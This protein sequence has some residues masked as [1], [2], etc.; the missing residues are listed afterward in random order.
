METR[1][2][3]II[4]GS[5]VLGLM[6]G[7]VFFLIWLSQP[8]RENRKSYDIQFRQSVGGLGKGAQVTYSG[9][10]V[11][12]VDLVTLDSRNPEV[13]QVRI[14]I[15]E[16]VPV[17]APSAQAIA[18][19]ENDGT[20]ASLAQSGFTGPILVELNTPRSVGG[21]RAPLTAPGPYEGG[22]PLI[23]PRPGGFAAILNNAPE[24]LDQ[25]RQLAARLTDFFSERNQESIAL[26]LENVQVLT[27]SLGERGPEIAATLAEARLTLRRAGVAIERFGQLASTSD[28]LLRREGPATLREVRQLLERAQGT[29]DSA[30]ATIAS[31]RPA[32]E[33]VAERT[34]PDV[35][36]LLR[37]LR[38]T[39][40]SLRRVAERLEQRGVGG[41][42]GSERLPD[43]EPK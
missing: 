3:Q 39:S 17:V 5:V 11:G 14:T 38:A 4:V 18:R 36:A 43:Y 1:S 29:L 27:R 30:S 37:D 19:G 25:F 6:V 26:I 42:I 35:S 15:D 20:T 22:L 28:E 24:V 41:L 8:N 34:L 31:A 23:P 40:E 12:Q 21:E 32:L 9:V 2:N 7:L 16:K 13:I 10:P 33:T